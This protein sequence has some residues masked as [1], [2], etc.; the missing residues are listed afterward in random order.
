MNQQIK[1]NAISFDID[2]ENI[3]QDTIT[4]KN[5][6]KGKSPKK[7]EV[8]PNIEDPNEA[9]K[10]Q[11]LYQCPNC[12]RK[13]KR[14]AYA[15]HV[16]ICARVFQNKKEPEHPK[17]PEKKLEKPPSRQNKGMSSKP[18]WENQSNELRA[19]IQSKRAEKTN[20]KKK[21]IK[22][23]I[24]E[25]KKHIDNNNKI[26][27]SPTNNNNNRPLYSRD[28]KGFLQCELCNKKFTKINFESHL[29]DCKQKY[30]DKKNGTFI[31]GNLGGSVMNN[32]MKNNLNNNVNGSP[33]S[34]KPIMPAVT[35]GRNKPNFSV[36][37]G[38]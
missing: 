28:N 24:E 4:T 18:K 10:E 12:S 37:F 17:I 25:P 5:T 27:G 11:V 19:I 2:F 30:K 32:N 35:Y 9:N 7:T 33:V 23:E 3:K 20:D 38:K 8:I 13:F 6:N 21:E 14:E 22:I 1:K 26:L 31:R 29:N 34:R 16:P 15:K 36:K